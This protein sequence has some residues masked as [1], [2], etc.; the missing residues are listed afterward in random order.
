[1]YISNLKIKNYRNF[2][3]FNIKLKPLTLI[4]GENNI[5]K[6]NLL[7]SLGLIFSQDISIYK[8]RNLE[9]S[10][11][12]Y[13]VILQYKRDIIDNE[14]PLEEITFPVIEIS[15]TL[16]DWDED[17]ESVISDW[18]V[19]EE[20]TEAEL[21]YRYAPVSSFDRL[22][23]LATQRE[24]INKFKI[25]IGEEKFSEL[26]EKEILDLINFPISKYYYSIIG[27]NQNDTQANM[28]H[29]NQLKFELLDALRDAKLELSAS[30][31]GNLL[32]RVLNAKE[33]NE[34]QDLKKQLVGLHNSIKENEAIQG[35]KEGISTQLDKISL[36]TEDFTNNINLIFS[37]PNVEDILK[38]LSLIYGENP[39][40]IEHNGTG[41]NNLLFMS[42][43][44]SYI[45]DPSSMESNYF[46]VVGIEEPESHLHA[47]LQNHLAQNIELLIKEEGSNTYRK[48]IQLI[49][50]SHSNHITTKIDFDNTVVLYKNDNTLSTHYV[51][52]G[53]SNNAE[54]RKRIKYLRKYLDAEN[55]NLFYSRK[56]ILVEGIS[57]KLLLPTFFK[58]ETSNT[59]EKSSC[60]V[61]NI[62][63]LAFKNF[64]DIVKNGYHTKC[65]VLTD[66]DIN[67]RAEDRAEN[68]ADLYSDIDQISVHITNESTFEKDII[69]SN[70]D[71]LGKDIL[72][73][74]LKQVRP[75]SGKQY[76]EGLG[77]N[78]IDI[79]DYFDLIEN[80]K[81]DFAYQLMIELE[82][83]N[84]G[85]TVP[86]YIKSGI[87][88]LNGSQS[89]DE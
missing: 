75:I 70:K 59:I 12:N 61:V 17:Q 87:L 81:S 6:S 37:L 16:V 3:D 32:F 79:E 77:E 63:G 58:I 23:E 71:G 88:F 33:E 62:N 76:G 83:N 14:K 50:V 51:L 47:N 18:Y 38:K 15:A 5:G 24:F 20:L 42:L 13:D 36:T 48:D 84:S 65:L 8:K 28:Y 53:F 85:F 46:R 34:Y 21:T 56:I 10:D 55:I 68:L 89:N 7:N 60:C 82:E 73:K 35:I 66:S 57:E 74:V 30:H 67:T 69:A 40:K 31:R 54:D 86:D 26:P 2:K 64:L 44:L 45:E 52:D 22:A 80:F 11:F 25:D 1:M 19:N 78:E 9:V 43:I 49:L 39:L 41:R 4:V 27:G 72:L 29:L